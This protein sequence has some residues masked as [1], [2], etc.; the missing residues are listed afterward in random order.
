MIASLAGVTAAAGFLDGV[1]MGGELDGR[2][3]VED[4]VGGVAV[5]VEAEIVDG[6]S[7]LDPGSLW[8]GAEGQCP[9]R[10][11][12]SL[13]VDVAGNSALVPV[14]VYA[15]LAG[16]RRIGVTETEQ[17]FVLEMNG[18]DGATGYA[19]RLEFMK[20]GKDDDSWAVGSR[21]VRLSSA[22]DQRFELFEYSY[23]LFENE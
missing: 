10:R 18:G 6:R 1:A 2:V 3:L 9:N 11:I 8:W 17:G 12:A 15:D 19:A 5:S 20:F 7:C 21:S 22:P 4:V 16:L 23:N 14:S 13:R